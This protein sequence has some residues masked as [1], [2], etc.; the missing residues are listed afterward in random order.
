MT[1]TRIGIMPIAGRGIIAAGF[2]VAFTFATAADSSAQVVERGLQGALGGA[3][4]GGIA[5]GGKG[6]GRGAIAGGVVGAIIG[7]IEAD[8]RHGHPPPPPPRRGAPPPPPRYTAAP[9]PPRPAAPREPSPNAGLVRD[10]QQALV[11]LGYDPGPV[12]GQYGGRTGQAISTYQG[13]YN[14]LVDGNAT[15][16]LLEHMRSHGG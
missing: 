14:L 3:I 6:A 1:H 2:A 12:D 4:I 11:N 10:I 7:G 8:R 5:G 13:D 16:Q 15:P 9:P